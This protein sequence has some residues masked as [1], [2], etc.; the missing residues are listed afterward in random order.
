MEWLSCP[1]CRSHCWSDH[2]VPPFYRHLGRL[3]GSPALQ[4]R[5]QRSASL[6]VWPPALHTLSLSPPKSFHS[7]SKEGRKLRLSSVLKYF[8]KIHWETLLIRNN[9]SESTEIIWRLYLKPII[10]TTESSVSW[11]RFSQGTL[12]SGFIS[13]FA[14]TEGKA[15]APQKAAFIQTL[16]E[17]THFFGNYHH[18]H[19]VVSSYEL[20]MCNLCCIYNKTQ[21]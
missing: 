5:V 12:W 18:L 19:L 9:L 21:K 14:W 20:L 11:M 16:R 7:V 15:L 13:S 10:K 2:S 1:K 3:Q 8:F 17:V 4:V 6:T